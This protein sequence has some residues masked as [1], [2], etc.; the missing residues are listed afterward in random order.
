MTTTTTISTIEQLIEVR[1]DTCKPAR[2]WLAESGI[3][4][5][6]DAW[7]RCHRGDWMLWLDKALDLLTDRERRLIACRCVR[8][9]PLSDG[10]RVWDLLTDERSRQAVAVAERY[11]VG[12]ATEE[13]LADAWNAA[14]V[15]AYAARAAARDAARAAARDAARAA[16]RDAAKDAAYA[17]AAAT[18]AADADAADATRA[19]A[20]YA[21]TA[22]AAATAAVYATQ[23]DI[24]R[25]IAGNP[26]R[27]K[28]A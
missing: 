2:E 8:E 3:T 14:R 16:A 9:T 17:V 23:A 24:I 13:Q 7:D 20:A 15:A 22:Y 6:A 5:L 19:Y 26:W 28:E 18:A 27:G 10:R 4:D 21:A 11:A 12:D 1:P 25:A